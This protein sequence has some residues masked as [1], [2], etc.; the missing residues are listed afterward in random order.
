MN[1][2]KNFQ[3]Q[4][5]P[6]QCQLSEHHELLEHCNFKVPVQAHMSKESLFL[7]IRTRFECKI[8]WFITISVIIKEQGENSL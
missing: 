5:V 7:F 2:H 3:L 6:L 4:D 8:N 1:K